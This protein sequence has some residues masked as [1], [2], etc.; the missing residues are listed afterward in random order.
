MW[1]EARSRGGVVGRIAFLRARKPAAPPGGRERAHLLREGAGKIVHLRHVRRVGTARAEC[2]KRVPPT[3]AAPPTTAKPSAQRISRSSMSE[4][5]K[6]PVAK[7]HH[8]SRQ[9][10]DAPAPVPSETAAARSARARHTSA[11]RRS[12]ASSGA[13]CSVSCRACVRRESIAD[14]SAP[15]CT[16]PPA[17]RCGGRSF[18]C[19][20]VPE[21]H[22]MYA[23][24]LHG[25]SL[26]K[27]SRYSSK[28]SFL[29]VSVASFTGRGGRA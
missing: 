18:P 24:N 7:E 5:V 4:C 25:A 8:R 2:G 3:K 23:A 1:F 13:K 16:A 21:I 19:S 11:R 28:S 29:S 22:G 10:A 17:P 20:A 9:C 14:S 26:L 6:V 15:S 27:A 12:R